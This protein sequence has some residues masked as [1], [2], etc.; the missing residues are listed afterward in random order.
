MVVA[1]LIVTIASSILALALFWRLMV[2]VV[3]GAGVTHRLLGLVCLV[4]HP[5]VTSSLACPMPDSLALALLVGTFLVL[6]QFGKGGA[7]VE[8]KENCFQKPVNVKNDD[9][10]GD[11]NRHP[12][13]EQDNQRQ[14]YP[15]EGSGQDFKETVNPA[16]GSVCEVGGLA[17]FEIIFFHLM[18]D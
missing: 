13:G 12:P 6:A 4:L 11:E 14:S 17:D 15:G 7:Q 18:M 8:R 5:G 2:W 1:H 16:L 3:P 9:E 10:D